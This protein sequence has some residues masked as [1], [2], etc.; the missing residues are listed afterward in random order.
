MSDEIAVLIGTGSIG[1]AVAR[2][3]A[4]GR[5]LLLAD[6][7]SAQLETT[8]DLLRGEGYDVRTRITDV[9]DRAAVTALA[10]TAAG[11]GQVARV[12][13]AAGVSPVQAGTDRVVHVDL[14]GT[15]YVLDAFGAVI[16]PGGSGIVIASMAGHLG[17]GFAPELE[18][19]LAY[20]G[21]DELADLPALDPGTI[22][23]SG[24][25]Y[26]LAKR[27][28]ALRVQAAAISWGERGSRINCLSPGIISTPFARD[29][30]TG[31]NAAGYQAMITTSAAGRMGT[32]AEVADLAALLLGPTG[33]FITGTDILIDGGVIAAQKAGKL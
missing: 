7:N 13:H 18:H 24:A 1:V 2:R 9:S 17:P 6:Y 21:V 33:S 10:D 27:A 3:A 4:V 11:L 8:A 28:N 16:A 29:E 19:A 20:A 26:V 5:T 30:M 32:P 31:P 23:N 25:A 12:V 15:A 22:G 14:L